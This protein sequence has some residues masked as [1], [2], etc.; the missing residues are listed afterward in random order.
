[1]NHGQRLGL[2]GCSREMAGRKLSQYI[3]FKYLHESRDLTGCGKHEVVFGHIHLPIVSGPSVDVPKPH[4][5]HL[6]NVVRGERVIQIGLID[7]SLR[8]RDQ[9]FGFMSL[10]FP[11][12]RDTQQVAQYPPR[13][14]GSI[15][16]SAPGAP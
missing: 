3:L 12:G 9:G 14:P 7:Q 15:S 13:D 8:S 10:Y 1:M 6:A 4:P 11:Y 2:L 16:A 5:M